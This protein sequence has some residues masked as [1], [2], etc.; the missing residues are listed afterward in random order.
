MHGV[1]QG[2]VELQQRFAAGEY[3]VAG[4][5][6]QRRPQAGD[7]I[8][9]GSGGR[10]LVAEFAIGADEIGV[11]EAA[12]GAGTVRFAPGPEVAA[13]EAA[14]HR[15]A[16]GLRAFALEGIE[17]LFYAVRQNLSWL[18]WGMTHTGCATGSGSVW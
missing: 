7:G 2:G 3:D 8:G 17:N 4:L 12:D 16:T 1:D 5:R 15:R 11:A 9:Q 13:G 10:L 6:M 14:K 18:E